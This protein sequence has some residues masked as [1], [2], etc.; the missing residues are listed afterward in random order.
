MNDCIFC[1]IIDGTIPSFKIHENEKFLVLLDRFPSC[2]GHVLV[3]PKKHAENIFELDSETASEI[4]SLV[5]D[6]AKRMKDVLPLEGLNIL[7]NNGVAAQQTVP[8]FHIHLIPRYT[9]DDITIHWDS[10]DPKIENFEKTI[11]TLQF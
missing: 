4:F 1:K 11:A 6:V 3:I 5:A 9:D 10:I 2:L 8:H 7:Q